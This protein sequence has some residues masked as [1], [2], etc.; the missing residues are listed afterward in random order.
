MPHHD[1]T[2]FPEPTYKEASEGWQQCQIENARLQE[3]VKELED[4]QEHRSEDHSKRLG[5]VYRQRDGY[6]ARAERRGEALE[7]VRE[8]W[9]FIE[10]AWTDSDVHQRHAPDDCDS[11]DAVWDMLMVI[12]DVVL[13][14]TKEGNK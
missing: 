6:K 14:G 13:H 2:E 10:V 3:H 9:E 7:A 12:R 11:C 5:G 1:P 4:E 8:A